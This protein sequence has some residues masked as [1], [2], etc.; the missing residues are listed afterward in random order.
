MKPKHKQLNA[1]ELKL[2]KQAVE[3]GVLDSSTI[4]R[5]EV[6]M[7]GRMSYTRESMQG[8]VRALGGY[9]TNR[10]TSQ[11]EVLVVGDTGVHGET[12]KIQAARQRGVRIITEDE[13]TKLIDGRTS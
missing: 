13:F 12:N 6:A 2:I 1:D 3:L 11:T 8:L 9:T 10:V 5:R 4:A 7:T